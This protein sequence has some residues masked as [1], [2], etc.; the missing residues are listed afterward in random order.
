MMLLHSESRGHFLHLL[1]DQQTVAHLS[2]FWPTLRIKDEETAASKKP[3]LNYHSHINTLLQSSTLEAIVDTQHLRRP[4]YD[5]PPGSFFK[6][7]FEEGKEFVQEECS[8][9]HQPFGNLS[10]LRLRHLLQQ[11]YSDDQS[12][13]DPMCSA[14]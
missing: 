3:R 8:R 14:A 2:D 7:N 1:Q 11:E 5:L 4:I 6:A 9:L 13:S 10:G 12:A